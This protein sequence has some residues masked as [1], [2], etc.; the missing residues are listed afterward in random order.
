M[1][2]L[3]IP[4]DAG[5]AHYVYPPTTYNVYWG[6]SWVGDASVKS[7]EEKARQLARSALSMFPARRLPKA[8]RIRF[9]VTWAGGAAHALDIHPY[10]GN[11]QAN[12]ADDSGVTAWNRCDVA[13][14]EYINDADAFRTIG[15]KNFDLGP[16][17]CQ[18]VKDAKEAV[19][20]Y[21]VA[22]HEEGDDDPHAT[23]STDIR[24][25]IIY[26]TGGLPANKA[27]VPMGL[28]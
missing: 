18:H 27:L 9:T 11:G 5:I 12:P 14:T 17:A 15:V 28:A 19:N 16:S 20:R 23:C 1:A 13:F 21:T 22:T 25:E 7:Q 2:V 4:A 8:V 24:L 6:Y 26:P 10:N 3:T